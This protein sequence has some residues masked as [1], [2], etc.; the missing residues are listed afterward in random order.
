MKRISISKRVRF[1]IFSRDGFT[2]KYC[3]RQSD[4]VPLHVDH[5]LPV[6]QGGTNDPENLI[7]SCE[8]CNLGKGGKT[9]PQ[10]IPTE[11]DRLRL[12][13]ERNEQM[14]T[15]KAAKAAVKARANL[16]QEIVNYWCQV[17]GE[18]EL[19]GVSKL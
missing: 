15:V 11:S 2:C 14:K 1:D 12:A 13:Q 7:T 18:E 16:R 4:V 6:C 19:S 3:G 9:I 8:E 17:R 5:V 10:H